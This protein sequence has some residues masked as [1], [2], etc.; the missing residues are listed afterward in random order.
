MGVYI[1]TFR[2]SKAIKMV[3][4]DT[5]AP[6]DHNVHHYAFCCKAGDED[7]NSWNRCDERAKQIRMQMGTAERSFTKAVAESPDGEVLVI[8]LR[9]DQY[10]VGDH[11]NVYR[12]R[13]AG[14]F[15]DTEEPGE[16][17]GVV[18]K[19]DRGSW[20]FYPNDDWSGGGSLLDVEDESTT[21]LLSESEDQGH[22]NDELFS[23]EEGEDLTPTWAGLMPALIGVLENGSVAV[24]REQEYHDGKA[25]VR[26]EL[27][28]L[29]EF[30]DRMNEESKTK[31]EV[32]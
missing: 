18:E 8:E 6:V 31:S 15:Y 26:S 10:E 13:N 28:R 21:E 17:V 11:A 32:K 23:D 2:K 29:A 9:P 3:F 16:K 7:T 5:K 30:A 4:A 27:M 20:L 22:S 14:I 24:G 12:T 1:N 25:N 19:T